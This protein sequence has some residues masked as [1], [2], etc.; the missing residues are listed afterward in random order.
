MR[1]TAPRE[2]EPIR[3]VQTKSGPRYRVTLDVARPGEKR[4]QVTTTHPSLK[5]ARQHVAETRAALGKG[6]YL[7]PSGE[8]V[9]A[10][11]TRWLA[12]RVDVRAVTR[13]GYTRYLE[14]VRRHLGQRTVQSLTVADAD[15]LVAW[16]SA[17]GAKQ[18]GPLAPRS[19]RACMVALGQALDLAMREDAIGRNVARL[20]KR[21]RSRAVVGRDLEHWSPGELAAFVQ[22]A[23]AHPWAAAWRLSASGLTRADVC[24]LRW[25]DVDLVA[26]TVTISQGRTALDHG[27]TTD[28]P[29]SER[30]RRTVPYEAAWPGTTERLRALRVQQTTDRL[31]AGPAWAG[32]DLVV[33]DTLGVP[34]APQIY[35]DHFR[36]IVTAAGLPAIRLHSLRHSLAFALHGQGVSPADA[37]ALLGHSVEMHLQTYLPSSGSSGITTAAL[38]LGRSVAG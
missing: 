5:A 16:L 18:G 31:A 23:D 15:A 38:A 14:P 28:D 30:R 12:S 7:A 22:A 9:D 4:R 25:Q 33:L 29:K 8:T 6:S 3:L 35:S 17:S 2:G 13:E 11:C 32:S 24:G 26:G 1:V 36:R 10:L 27:D 21:P 19:V 34:V 37:A 20:A